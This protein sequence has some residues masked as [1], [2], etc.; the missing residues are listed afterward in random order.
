MHYEGAL[1]GENWAPKKI[2]IENGYIENGNYYFYIKDHLGNNR[3]VV[4]AQGTAVQYT[5]YYPFGMPFD[6]SYN[7]GK[8]VQPYK[9]GGK[10]YD[11]RSGLNLYDFHARQQNPEIAGRF[12]TM[13]PLAEK[14]YSWSPYVYCMNNPMKY[15]DPTGMELW[16][17]EYDEDG[18][19]KNKMRYTPGMTY[20]GDNEYFKNTPGYVMLFSALFSFIISAYSRAVFKRLPSAAEITAI[21]Q[22]A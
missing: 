1:L 12:T 8:D 14:Y 15:V 6:D 10:E 7:T 2:L 13:D 19:E 5:D 21:H 16:L 11:T 18:N 20:K 9:F 4:D 17:Y 3:V 22:P